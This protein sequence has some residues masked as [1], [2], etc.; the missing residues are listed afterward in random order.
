MATNKN[1]RLRYEALDKCFSNFSRKFFIEDL[2]E[3]CARYL[4]QEGCDHTEVSKSQIYADIRFMKNSP[5][6]AAPI[7]A[8]WDGQRRYYR[9]TEEGFSIVDL[10]DEELTELETTVKMLASFKGMPQFDWMFD[11]VNKLKKK[12]KVR[13][14]AK[15]FL[16]FDSNIDLQGLDNF[17]AIFGY[18]A[19]EQ[20]I[21]I[22]YEPFNKPQ[23]T[24]VL[25]PYF[26]KQYN[27]RWFLLG[28]NDEFKK[29]SVF[30]IDR[31]ISIEPA[32]AKFIPDHYIVDPED[33]FYNVIGVTIPKEQNPVNVVLRF[34]EHRYPYVK[35]K[36]IH[37]T[38]RINDQE[39]T[40]AINVVLNKELVSTILSFGDDVE[41]VE[42]EQLRNDV[43]TILLSSCKKY[44][45]V[46]NDST[47]PH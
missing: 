10:T 4:F 23:F 22:V 25:H 12:Y 30:A 41:V 15:S 19:N 34:S 40:V 16:S 39:C 14:E 47:S 6:M 38:Q 8:Q 45:L 35:A 44:G 46:K 9:Y 33:Y 17:K 3:A 43:A 27:N 24:A 5:S 28:L 36:P 42:P 7:K 29:I 18:I 13:G 21:A 11:I 1:A 2:Q 26:L 20:P 37:A 32:Q 31:I